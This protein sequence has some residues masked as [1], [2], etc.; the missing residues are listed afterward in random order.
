M[1][2]LS[3]IVTSAL[4]LVSLNLSSCKSNN[5]KISGTVDILPELQSRLS[6]QAV[7]YIVARRE[8]Q[9]GGPPAVVK[10]FTQPLIFPIEF[11]LSK[12]DTMIPDSP[13]DGKY[14]VTAR[15]AQT[16]S[17]TPIHSGDIKGSAKANPILVGE[18]NLKI[19]LSEVQ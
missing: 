1:K 5:E 19:T 8:D 10:R 3:P 2:A 17:A 18:A 12:Q 4:I 9:T 6:P 7:L 15:I 13:F 16:G 14:T 11:N